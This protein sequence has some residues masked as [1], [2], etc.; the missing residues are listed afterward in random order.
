MLLLY[1]LFCGYNPP[2]IFKLNETISP[3]HFLKLDTV[4]IIKNIRQEYKTINLNIPRY[5]KIEKKNMERS[6]EGGME[7]AYFDGEL[8]KRI[9]TDFCGEMGKGKTEYYFSSNELIFIYSIDYYYDSPMYNKGSK[10]D[11]TLEN[12]FYFY[13]HSLIKWINPDSKIIPIKSEKFVLMEKYLLEEMN[14][15]FQ[16]LNL[17]YH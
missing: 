6:S 5:K 17:N 14:Y 15:I 2:Q 4:Q 8:L 7:I 16:D 13:N 12:R 1:I 3:V 11:S 10:I 9:V